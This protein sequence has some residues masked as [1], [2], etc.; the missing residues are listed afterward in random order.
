MRFT[1]Q[2]YLLGIHIDN[3]P[4]LQ[5]YCD[6]A[7]YMFEYSDR[8]TRYIDGSKTPPLLLLSS[9]RC[10]FA[11]QLDYPQAT[12]RGYPSMIHAKEVLY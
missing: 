10:V 11:D 3:H 12:N 2:Q 6:E 4:K 9:R 5:M 1:I 8:G 7:E